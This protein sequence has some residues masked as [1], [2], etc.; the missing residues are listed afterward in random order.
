MIFISSGHAYVDAPF[1][2]LVRDAD[3]HHWYG[4]CTSLS[5]DQLALT[6]WSRERHEL[7]VGTSPPFLLCSWLSYAL[8][9]QLYNSMNV[10]DDIHFQWPCLSY[11]CY[12]SLSIFSYHLKSNPLNATNSELQ[13][14]FLLCSRAPANA[15]VW[16]Y[17]FPISV[18]MYFAKKKDTCL[19]TYLAHLARFRLVSKTK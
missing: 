18:L 19:C 5:V 1:I 2:Q 8:P 7:W 12:T 9:I 10:Y 17:S 11:G 13:S 3:T 15:I 16:W 4:R 14:P 6:F